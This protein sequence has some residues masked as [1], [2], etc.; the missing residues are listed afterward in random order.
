M[1]GFALSNSLLD[2]LFGTLGNPASHHLHVES[3]AI[4]PKTIF[5]LLDIHTKGY[6]DFTLIDEE[7]RV[8]MGKNFE[9]IHFVGKFFTQVWFLTQIPRNFPPK[10]K[11]QMLPIFLFFLL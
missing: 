10:K 11:K 4:S 3:F 2:Y 7:Q 1:Q 6:L 5:S 9:S 8:E